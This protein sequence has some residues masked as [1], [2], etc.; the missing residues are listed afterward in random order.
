ML[1]LLAL[2]GGAAGVIGFFLPLAEYTD[3]T[4]AVLHTSSAYEIAITPTDAAGLADFIK[5]FGVAPDQAARIE[6]AANTS[7]LAHRGAIIAFYVP[8]ALLALFSLLNLVRARVGRF[9]GF[10]TL[11]LGAA[12]GAVFG[13]FWIGYARSTD[14]NTMLGYG[15][16]ALA[17]ASALGMLAGLARMFVPAEP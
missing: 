6:H 10:L 11:V 14:P 4:G 5:G 17:A 15:V 13:Y 16:W 3:Q 2:L 12:N 8:A 7:L 1:K 9:A